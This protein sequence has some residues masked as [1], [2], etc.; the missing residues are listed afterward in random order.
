MPAW[1]P[2]SCAWASVLRSDHARGL[3]TLRRRPCPPWHPG[4]PSYEDGRSRVK[5]TSFSSLP[6]APDWR[7]EASAD[8]GED[9]SGSYSTVNDGLVGSAWQVRTQPSLHFV[10]GQG[11]VDPHGDRT[12]SDEGHARGA[13]P[14]LAGVGRRHARPGGRSRARCHRRGRRSRASCPG[15]CSTIGSPA[16]SAP[17]AS[18]SGGER[19]RGIDRRW[20]T[21]R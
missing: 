20:R 6:R 17:S 15:G 12:L 19:C 10:W 1:A 14:G 9:Q 16:S 5:R 4:G 3:P 11:V 7:T 21:A 18:R 8:R 13:A 2:V